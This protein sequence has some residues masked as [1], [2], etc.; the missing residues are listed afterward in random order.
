VARVAYSEKDLRKL[1]FNYNNCGKDTVERREAMGAHERLVRIIPIVGY[2]HSSFHASGYAADA[3]HMSWPAYSG[4]TGGI[5]AQFVLPRTRQQF[6][7]LTDVLYSHFY[8]KS[9]PYY[10]NTAN[11]ETG[12][13][14]YN[15][16]QWDILFRYQFPTGQVRPFVN[17]GL[18]NSFLF[19]NKSYIN[20]HEIGA[21]VDTHSSIFAASTGTGM[22][23]Y[24]IGFIA[25]AGVSIGRFSLEARIQHSNGISAVEDI[26]APITDFSLLAGFSF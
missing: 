8:S 3:V 18:S 19:N 23:S 21:A 7:F 2:L 4:I 20:D 25:G 9:S 16:W 5:G 1:V 17:A 11:T 15:Q 24:E 12:Y 14:Q 10:A 26:S 13:V 22:S 6:S